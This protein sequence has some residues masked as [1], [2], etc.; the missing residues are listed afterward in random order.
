LVWA[1]GNT[2]F[3]TY[4]GNFSNCKIKIPNCKIKKKTTKLLHISF[5][6]FSTSSTFL[7]T[8]NHQMSTLNDGTKPN[9]KRN[10]FLDRWLLIKSNDDSIKNYKSTEIQF[11]VVLDP[12]EDGVTHINVYSK[13]K[14]LLGQLLSNMA[15][16]PFVHPKHGKFNSVEGLWWYLATGLC[17]DFYRT[18]KAFECKTRGP[19]S[20]LVDYSEFREDL[21]LG[22]VAKLASHANIMRLL[23]ENQLPLTHYYWYGQ[24]GQVK[25][26]I[27]DKDNLWVI[28]FLNTFRENP[29]HVCVTSSPVN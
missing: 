9:R 5:W 2:H 26:I 28:E 24:E 3:L 22:I 19:K 21:K 11:G 7:L 17:D 15:H 29:N 25:K 1:V 10:K 4:G 20:T 18:A 14:T 13:A 12:A 16:T 27:A 6:P 23:L 8:F